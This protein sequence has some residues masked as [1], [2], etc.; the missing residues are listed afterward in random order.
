MVIAVVYSTF[1]GLRGVML[2]D[3]V[4]F[5]LAMAGSLF[6]AAFALGA[7]GG[8]DALPDKLA[9][10]YGNADDILS[11]WPTS[12]S[13]WLPSG[14]F[15]VYLGV[16]WWSHK[17]ADGGG[18][19]VQRMGATR[20]SVTASKATM[21][22][23]IAHYALRPWPWIIVGL[24][25]LVI[26]PLASHPGLDREAVYPMLGMRLLPVGLKGV[27]VTSLL[28]A[29]MSTIDT[30]IN[31]G[32]SYLV[33]DIYRRFLRPRASQ[34]EL[35]LVSRACVVLMAVVALVAA[36]V[37][38]S[39]HA[40][41]KI[42][43]IL[44]SGWGPAI[45]LRWLW[46]R[47]NAWT[48]IAAITSGSLVGAVCWLLDWPYH[49]VLLIT[50]LVA[51]IASIVATM[52]TRPVPDDALADFVSKVGPPGL[53]GRIRGQAS[54]LAV[55]DGA[56]VY[57]LRRSLVTWVAAVAMLY[58]ALFGTGYMLLGS[59]GVGACLLVVAA[60]CGY[61]TWHRMRPSL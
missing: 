32:A 25:A 3:V 7:V 54:W 45:V 13:T 1:G 61:I 4:Q 2:T 49:H 19:F 55:G 50:V 44:G 12:D 48:E 30:H 28:A 46:W 29:F 60:A 5:F 16:Q 42:F 56:P 35:V 37:M 47:A 52:L 51:T 8:L 41:W 14:V 53:W 9:A 40:G 58:S 17:Y 33:G 15:A 38:G 39:I 34:R 22:F 36:L 21:W 57:P 26:F 27:L 31:W 23:C 18:Y 24:C 59:P 6:L 20:D 11:F 43:H 10:T